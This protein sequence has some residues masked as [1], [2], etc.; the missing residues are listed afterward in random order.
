MS[1][2]PDETES[3]PEGDSRSQSEGHLPIQPRIDSEGDMESDSECRSQN[4][5]WTDLRSSVLGSGQATI[6]WPTPR[7]RSGTARKGQSREA[8]LSDERSP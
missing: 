1:L 5:S 8:D 7:R 6:R 4:D 2:L 3:Q